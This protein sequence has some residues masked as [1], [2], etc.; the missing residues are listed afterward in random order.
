M[1]DIDKWLSSEA[2]DLRRGGIWT[3]GDGPNRMQPEQWDTR[4]F[5][6]LIARLS[7]W[8]DTIESYTH[9]A[10]HAMLA[11]LPGVF[12]DL[13]WVPPY[14]DGERLTE[15]GIPWLFGTTSHRGVSEFD[16]LALSNALVQE[17]VNIPAVLRRS[18]I[19]LS[20][21]ERM[22]RADLP[23]VILGG[24]NALYTSALFSDD[25]MVDG[26]F[27]G[28][29]PSDIQ[30]IFT[31]LAE[32]KAAGKSK[33]E[34]LD[35]LAEIPGFFL[36]TLRPVAKKRH[37]SVPDVAR[38]KPYE[39]VSAVT[40][41]VDSASLQISEGCPYFCSFCAES[42]SRKPYRES[43]LAELRA[44]ALEIKREQGVAKI[45]LYSFNFNTHE[46]IRPLI[47]GL[48]EDF[49]SVGLKS[50]RFDAIAHDP[51][52]TRLLKIA[53]KTSITCGL[54]GISGRLRRFLQKDLSDAELR[55]S[56]QALLRERLRELKVFMIATGLE[57]ESDYLEFRGFLRELR[58]LLD[59]AASK[60][61]VT[62]SATALVR[63]PWTPLEF[64]AMPTAKEMS[65][66]IGWIKA[67]VVSAG[68]EFRAAAPVEEAWVSQVLVRA[69]DQRV[70]EAV[71]RAQDKTNYVFR[72]MVTPEFYDALRAELT[73]HGDAE[74]FVQAA[75]P[76]D[77]ASAPW[78]GLDPGVTRRF[79]VSSW[80]ACQGM[81]QEEVC[82]GLVDKAGKCGACGSC[83]PAERDAITHA[84]SWVSQDLDA[85]ERRLKTLRATETEIVIDVDLSTS[86]R[87][88]PMDL[89]QTRH[90]R[91]WMKLLN[92]AKGYRRHHPHGRSEDS[93]DCLA[94]GLETL[95]PVFLAP[96]AERVREV[97]ASSE[98]LEELNQLFAPY[99]RIIGL[100][101]PAPA[102]A[103]W[104]F[105]TDS[106]IDISGWLAACGLKH[107]FRRQGTT[108][109]YELAKESLKKKILVSLCVET[110]DTG[111]RIVMQAGEKF[112]VGAF[113]RDAFD[114]SV[115]GR[116][117]AHRAP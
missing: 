93:D 75:E 28:E 80:R 11:E 7:T 92:D 62:F 117:R 82:L 76:E 103:S 105:E 57:E 35:S 66:R 84:R 115:R 38:F 23:L 106:D 74:E 6:V 96:M 1:T 39:P 20:R 99:G 63:F 24:A 58:A 51:T 54:E 49:D 83:S 17:I 19:P 12:P 90:A 60:P 67:A 98:R 70:M 25:P 34:A 79:L 71:L 65:R 101:Q 8:D 89:I 4:G 69:R 110:H 104:T 26:I 78:I 61:R 48:L 113:L 55:S 77:E 87:G 100:A 3:R 56:L 46:E 43:P 81:E 107:T 37:G 14:A 30:R 41:S 88:L 97:L 10:L 73:E 16:C 85:L 50:Q 72:D 40:G 64:S 86:C 52:F 111:S 22:A 91:A 9:N 44:R 59:C 53:G 94:S 21:R 36:P 42:W 47:A 27:L 18:G 116:V 109:I 102:T 13:T 31:L 95:R 33:S 32:A 2:P 15:A 5:R 29:E 114:P 45:D 112:A 68:F 108:R